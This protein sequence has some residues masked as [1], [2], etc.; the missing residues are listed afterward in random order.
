MRPSGKARTRFMS[1][2][3]EILR[4]IS[5][6]PYINPFVPKTKANWVAFFFL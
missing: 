5:T 3:K 1:N 6:F 2:T 4:L